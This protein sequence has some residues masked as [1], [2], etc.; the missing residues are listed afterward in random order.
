MK[1]VEKG[2]YYNSKKL[3]SAQKVSSIGNLH[4][5]ATTPKA[6]NRVQRALFAECLQNAFKSGDDLVNSLVDAWNNALA[7]RI[8]N[9]SAENL[10][11][12]M[13]PKTARKLIGV[14]SRAMQST[15][16]S[17]KPKRQH[18]KT[19]VTDEVVLRQRYI[20]SNEIPEDVRFLY[21]YENIRKACKILRVT[22]YGK[23][24]KKRDLQDCLAKHMK[25]NKILNVKV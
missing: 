11:G 2:T 4:V 20:C 9:G 18:R 8:A 24:S 1:H 16:P 23:M 13:T 3:K 14:D 19:A 22:G 21:T 7:V 10:G 17:R 15:S 5:K 6:L 12:I 25:A